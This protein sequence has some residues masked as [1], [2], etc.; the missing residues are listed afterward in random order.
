MIT[1]LDLGLNH[2]S[3]VDFDGK[4]ILAIGPS[5]MGKSSLALQLIAL[6]GILVA[7]DQVVLSSDGKAAI[8]SAPPNIQGQ[9]EAR[10][11]G[12]LKC[13]NVDKSQLNL[14]V[15]LALEQ[16]ARLPDLK[17]VAVGSHH[18][19]L[20]AGKDVQNL[21]IVAKILNLFGYSQLM[22]PLK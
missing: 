13:P 19:N 16:T 6:G 20:I 9:I 12:I 14:I 8:V 22:D 18:V 10:G 11:V 17:T 21:P 1:E 2:G 5:G 15:D 3:C 4:S 7:D